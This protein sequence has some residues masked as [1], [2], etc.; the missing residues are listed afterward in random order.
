MIV[1]PGDLERSR[2]REF[3]CV[4]H[5][6]RLLPRSRNGTE[7]IS[8]D[9]VAL[10]SVA[11]RPQVRRA[12]RTCGRREI[13]KFFALTFAGSVVAA[14]A[15]RACSLDRGGPPDIQSPLRETSRNGLAKAQ[16]HPPER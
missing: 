16:R 13:E 14:L 4:E 10:S 9:R 7:V 2:G 11:A 12:R 1:E 3:G 5:S 8:M 6:G 15:T